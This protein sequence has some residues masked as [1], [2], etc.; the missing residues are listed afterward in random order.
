[1]KLKINVTIE[2]GIVEEVDEFARKHGLNRSQ[3]VQNMLSASLAEVKILRALGLLDIAVM[4]EKVQ[5]HLK[6]NLARG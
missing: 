4:V 1:M 3:T 5:E 6:L 2:E